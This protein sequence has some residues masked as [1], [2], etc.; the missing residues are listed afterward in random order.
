[1]ARPTWQLEQQ[2]ARLESGW[3]AATIDATRPDRGLSDVLPARGS[4]ARGSPARGSL[5]EAH[6]L[7]FAT[8]LLAP[9]RA[10]AP[11]EFLARGAELLVAYEASEGWPVRVDAGWRIMAPSLDAKMT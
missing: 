3:L 7:G 8:P 10:A 1:M 9:D 11:V 4:P 2:R 6:L 5:D